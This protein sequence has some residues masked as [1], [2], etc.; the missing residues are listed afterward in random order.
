MALFRA[1]SHGNTSLSV[2]SLSN[3]SLG[4]ASAAALGELLRINRVLRELDLSWNQIKVGAIFLVWAIAIN[5]KLYRPSMSCTVL[6][7]RLQLLPSFSR[8]ALC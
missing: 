3:N 4:N 2:L 7:L 1:L 6:S 8:P 5:F